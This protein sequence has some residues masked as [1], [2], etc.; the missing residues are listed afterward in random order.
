MIVFSLNI[1]QGGWL[2]VAKLIPSMWCNVLPWVIMVV[3]KLRLEKPN[4]R[5]YAA[6]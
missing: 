2:E 1:C 3:A 5:Y 4:G 6:S